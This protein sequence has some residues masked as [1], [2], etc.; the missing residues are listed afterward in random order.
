MIFLR[1]F[2]RQAGC[3]LLR[4]GSRS[5]SPISR[6]TLLLRGAVMKNYL[7]LGI[8][9]AVLFGCLLA[10]GSARAQ[11]DAE[12]EG[13]FIAMLKNAT[14]K[15]SWA[16]VTGGR[17]GGEKGDDSYKIARVE[18]GEGGKWNVVSV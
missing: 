4:C 17:L 8:P 18:K 11:G 1:W 10:A 12:V 15:G 13:K 3:G 6:E 16:P 7:L 9:T 14:L 2:E 5:G